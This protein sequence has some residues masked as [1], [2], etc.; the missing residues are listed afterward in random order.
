VEVKG[1]GPV[2]PTPAFDPVE[3]ASQLGAPLAT[4]TVPE[5]AALYVGAGRE[6]A[7]VPHG[8]DPGPMRIVVCTIIYRFDSDEHFAPGPAVVV[9]V[10]T[11]PVSG[12]VSQ[13]T[14]RDRVHVEM[15]DYQ[16]ASTGQHEVP[17]VRRTP[18]EGRPQPPAEVADRLNVAQVPSDW[19]HRTVRVDGTDLRWEFHTSQD[20]ATGEE[21]IGVGGQ[22]DGIIVAVVGPAALLG[23]IELT[24]VNPAAPIGR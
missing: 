21:I 1:T 7:H 3:L 12:E 5:A 13:A 14:V 15:V 17:W 18:G 24:L 11:K 20:V 4:L 23:Q 8:Q 2:P 19:G 6:T 10:S 9:A 16:H 22:L